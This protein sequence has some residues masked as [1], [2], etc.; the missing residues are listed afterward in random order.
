MILRS[1]CGHKLVQTA[2]WDLQR[3]FCYKR[4]I[5]KNK[6]ENSQDIDTQDDMDVVGCTPTA[7]DGQ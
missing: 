2:T 6:G 1:V 4:A 5:N 7:S 3:A